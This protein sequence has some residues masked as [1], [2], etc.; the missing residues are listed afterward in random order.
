[1]NKTAT[2]AAISVTLL[3][4][5]VGSVYLIQLNNQQAAA[6]VEPPQAA[7]EPNPASSGESRSLGTIS[8]AKTASPASAANTAYLSR[9]GAGIRSM[10]LGGAM[11]ITIDN[12]V[13]NEMDEMALGTLKQLLTEARMDDRYA[14]SGAMQIIEGWPEAP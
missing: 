3:L 13:V 4:L 12:D 9:L 5:G 10:D 1:M 6:S 11:L 7:K 2:F 14:K 8:E